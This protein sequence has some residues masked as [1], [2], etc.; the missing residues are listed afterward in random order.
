MKEQ[1]FMKRYIASKVLII[2]GKISP[3]NCDE[4]I[5][6]SYCVQAN[7]VLYERY[8]N[9]GGGDDVTRAA[10]ATIKKVGLRKAARLIGEYANT[11][12]R[13]IKAGNVPLNA[14]EKIA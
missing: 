10:I 12:S 4:N 14:I 13:W 11:V 7:L 3:C 9:K 8:I 2:N 6:C 1:M 5:I